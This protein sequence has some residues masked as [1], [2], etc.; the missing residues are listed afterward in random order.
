MNLPT[1][2]A[3]DLKAI[4]DGTDFQQLIL[5][6]DD[7]RYGVTNRMLW[8][9][10][11]DIIAAIEAHDVVAVKGCHASGKTFTA[12][13]IALQWICKYRT[14]KVYVIAPTMRQVKTFIG[15]VELARR[16]M[17]KGFGLP[18]LPECTTTGL[19]VE[20]NR[21]IR[22]ASA[23]R[24]VNL[25]GPH[26]DNV[27]IITD[28]SP[29]IMAEI[30][31]AV[32]GIRSGGNVRMLKLGNPV[33]P[34]GAFFD[35]FSGKKRGIN[36][37]TG[38]PYVKG[39]TIS[40]FDTPNLFNRD[41]GKPFTIDELKALGPKRLEYNPFPF[42]VKRSWVL[43][44]FLM[45]GP[46][47][48]KYLARVL[49]EFP[50]QSDW[51]VFSLEWIERMKR[52]PTDKEL[53]AA[54]GHQIRIGIDVAGGGDDESSLCARVDGIVLAQRHYTDRN[55]G[56]AMI[57]DLREIRHQY[58]ELYPMGTI[59]LDIVGVGLNLAPQIAEAGFHVVGFQAGARPR[60]QEQFENAKSEAYWA[61]RDFAKGGLICGLQDEETEAQLSSIQYKETYR[62][63]TAIERKEDAR[64]RGAHSPDRAEGLIQAF[65][66]MIPREVRIEYGGQYEIS[67]Y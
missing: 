35:D 19:E 31:D 66:P 25:Q 14:G 15:E 10:Q 56:G 54:V 28:E 32:E 47:H 23:S 17:R 16:F 67:P 52:D 57:A 51:A 42:L 21:Y 33:V 22:G 60:D 9:R 7:P 36:P 64:A 38:K 37:A 5:R 53:L 48:P 65:M 8:E 24:G 18:N 43:E 49:G 46:T 41:T 20:P 30:W 39:L 40:A 13:G 59:V 26:G 63:K 6:Y 58:A 3:A 50:T 34:S 44:R 11:R 1:I 55:P 62:G 27:L 4:D 45:W 2:S 61:V 29:G 12:S